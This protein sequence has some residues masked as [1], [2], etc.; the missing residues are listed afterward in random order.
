MPNVICH[1]DNIRF[2]VNTEKP[3]IGRIF[4][5]GQSKRPDCARDY[6]EA[7]GTQAEFELSLSNCGMMRERK[8]T[9]PVPI[10]QTIPKQFS[11]PNR[12]NYSNQLRFSFLQFLV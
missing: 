10:F 3:F 1:T 7:N 11:I 5:K 4:V 2:M 12:S 8:V 9:K 6:A